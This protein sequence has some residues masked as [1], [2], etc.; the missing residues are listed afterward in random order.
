L[1]NLHLPIALIAAPFFSACSSQQF[2][3]VGQTWQR[4]ECY[5]IND[6]QERSRCMSSAS[7][8]YEDYKRQSDAA[9][10]TK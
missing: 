2:Y 4:N 6:A 10:G 5:K 1:R 7:T 9:K 3:G 8:S